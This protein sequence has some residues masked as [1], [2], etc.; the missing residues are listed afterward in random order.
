MVVERRRKN[1]FLV[2]K[3]CHKSIKLKGEKLKITEAM[4]ERKKEIVIMGKGEEEAEL[5]K[6][7]IMCPRCENME[8]YWWMQQT[9]GTDEP[10]T[11]FYKCTKCGYSWRSYG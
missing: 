5:P 6:T 4:H 11:M 9:R 1:V 3:K 8:A 2:C 10:P 7:K